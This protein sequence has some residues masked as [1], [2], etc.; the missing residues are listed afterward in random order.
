MCLGTPAPRAP[1]VRYQGP[2]E[3]DIRRNQQQLDAYQQQM[4]AQQQQFQ[5]ALQSQIDRANSQYADLESQYAS[6]LGAATKK[7]ADALAQASAEGSA[8]LSAAGAQGL[9][10]AANAAAP[11]ANQSD[12]V[13]TQ[14]TKAITDKKKPKKSLRI[15][16]NNMAAALGAGLNIGV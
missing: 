15:G 8:A 6:E 2:S 14:E 1:E 3:A 13:E 10:D 12:P 7:G 16:M 9:V 4:A 5:S 11:G